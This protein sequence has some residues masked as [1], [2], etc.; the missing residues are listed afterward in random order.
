M[1]ST[2]EP[3]PAR[4]AADPFHLSLATRRRL[5]R[6]SCHL[7]CL[8]PLAWLLFDFW[9]GQLGPDP[10]RTIILRTGKASIVMLT[11]TLACTPARF[12][13]GWK[14]A[15]TVRRTLGLYTFAYVS[16]HLL[17]FV[18]LDYGFAMRLVMEEIVLRRYAV[19][20]FLAFLLLIPLAFTS[21]KRAQQRLGKR[22]KILHKVIY[23][24]GALAVIHYIWLVKNAYTQPILFAVIIGGLLIVRLG[25]VK[26]KILTLHMRRPGNRTYSE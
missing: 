11:L 26:R 16:L 21:N 15:N 18:W 24:V 19:A 14:Q 3:G 9:F 12:I 4:P 1:N 6:V 2:L 7:L 5:L 10:I 8:F 22:W 17:A 25:P 23:L 13:L 20:G